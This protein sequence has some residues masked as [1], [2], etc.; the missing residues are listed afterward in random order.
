MTSFELKK[1]PLAN[2]VTANYIAFS[3]TQIPHALTIILYK[4]I[5]TYVQM[6]LLI[7]AFTKGIYDDDSVLSR[8]FTY[9]T[10]AYL[11]INVFTNSC[12]QACH[13][14]LSVNWGTHLSPSNL[15]GG[16]RR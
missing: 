5:S 9:F 14:L 3:M 11:S 15:D 4:I 12:V 1:Q 13:P 16:F 7:P 2:F 10:H 6:F 8:P